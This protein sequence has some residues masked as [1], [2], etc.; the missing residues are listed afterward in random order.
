[1]PK[2]EGMA[3]DAATNALKNAGLELGT[4]IQRNDKSL[5]ANTV[6]SASEKA[7]AELAPDTVV[8]L[9]VASGKVTLTDL[10]GFTLDAAT[11]NLT[12][13]GLVPV[14]V[15]QADCAA[16]QPPTVNTMS[17]APGDV[18]IGSSIELR[19]CTGK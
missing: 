8:N 4:V 6:I 13:L 7:D 15:E 17:V 19:Y 3:L 1:M 16:T 12:D 18:P 11:A 9:V 10:R 5:A 2:I 14:P